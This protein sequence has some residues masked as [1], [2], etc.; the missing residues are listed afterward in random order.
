[1]SHFLM[2]KL[3]VVIPMKSPQR[4]K[5]RLANSMTDEARESL[6]LN[7]F[8]NTLAFFQTHFPRLDVLVVSESLEVLDLAQSYDANT[9]FDDGENGLNG[10]L[11]FASDWVKQSGYDS[12]LII[13]GDIAVLNPDEVQALITVADDAEV[14]IAVAKDGG[15]NALLTSPPDAIEFEY[16]HQSA[17]LHKGNAFENGLSCHSLNFT[18]L[19]LDIDQ[20]D[21]LKQAVIQAPE[22]FDAWKS[23]FISPVK[24]HQYA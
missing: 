21:D 1:M 23:C 19:A 20:S 3:C 14:V 24:E 22:R 5:Q 17:R 8:Q 12:Q 13:P 16:G 11:T 4:S 18:D 2:D 7:L 10:A 15:T 6:S 9:L